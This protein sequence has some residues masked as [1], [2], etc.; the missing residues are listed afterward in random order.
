MVCEKLKVEYT[1]E[2]HKQSAVAQDHEKQEPCL[3]LIEGQQRWAPSLVNLWPRKLSQLSSSIER[4]DEEHLKLGR[5]LYRTVCSPI[6]PC[7][8]LSLHA[9]DS[10]VN[11]DHAI[12]PPPPP[13]DMAVLRVPRQCEAQ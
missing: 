8:C 10:L 4:W 13:S 1:M 7:R 2:K 12:R 11:V 5:V 6:S 3:A 9:I